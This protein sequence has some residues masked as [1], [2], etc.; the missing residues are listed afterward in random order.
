MV[1]IHVI[2]KLPIHALRVLVLKAWGARIGPGVTIYHG[3]EIRS[4]R[5][6]QIGANTSVGNDAILDA[7]G[8]LV[9][10]SNVNLSTGVHIWTAQHDW[11]SQDFGLDLGG[12]VVG[13]H[14]WL[15]DRV[16]VLPG[17]TIGEGAVVA[18]GGLVTRDVGPFQL[19]G[20][21]PAKPLGVRP[22]NLTYDLP[23]SRHKV[24]WW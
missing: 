20:G 21:V 11:R 16:T 8:G 18:A 4:A 3:I 19:V 14:A 7:R 1:S 15:S 9:I 13:D 6:L 2:G 23:S 12:V 10:G 17:V 24:W 5:R 22:D